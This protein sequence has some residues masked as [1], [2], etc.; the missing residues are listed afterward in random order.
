MSDRDRCPTPTPTRGTSLARLAT[1]SLLAGALLMTCG[2]RPT[3]GGEDA[4]PPPPGADGGLLPS[5]DAGD[6]SDSGTPVDAGEGQD[7][8]DGGDA[9]SQGDAGTTSDAG[10][11]AT[12][13]A[14]SLPVD[15]GALPACPSFSPGARRI[16]KLLFA[17][18]L[19]GIAESRRNPGI[20]WVHNDS[21]G[22]AEVFAMA[23]NGQ[24]AATLTFTLPSGARALDWEDIAVGPG[25]QPSVSS[26]Y[27][28]DIG[29]NAVSRS[30]VVVYRVPEPSVSAPATLLMPPASIALPQVEAFTFSYPGSMRN[31]ETL[32][33][34]PT[35]GDLYIVEK[36]GNG[37][38]GVFRAAAPLSSSGV[39]M[40]Q[41]VAVLAFGQGALSGSAEATGGDIS[42]DGR[43]LIVRSYDRAFLWRR[44]PGATVADAFATPPCPIPLVPQN[45]GEALGFARDGRGYYSASEND[46]AIYFYER[47]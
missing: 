20:F 39:T 41:Q 16:T 44:A 28:G 29:S 14:G 19:S 32:L 8:G 15:G 4:G 31:A 11:G 23:S 27:V 26:I 5:T 38:S 42:P 6:G 13:D 36:R 9:G 45:Q 1:A 10:D 18:E 12:G 7:A 40:L 33:V 37:P 35:S 21:G 25:P 47:R 24:R 17:R 3:G 34:D 22:Q 2:E 43:E 46:D 30:T